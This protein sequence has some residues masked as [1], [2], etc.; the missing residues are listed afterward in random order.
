MDIEKSSEFVVNP[1]LKIEYVKIKVSDLKSSLDFYKSILGLTLLEERSN[2]NIAYL[3]PEAKEENMS[4]PILVLNQIERS[5]DSNKVGRV[6]KETGLYHFAILLPK[7]THLASFL[8]HVKNNLNSR[9]YEGMADHA[10][11]ESIYLHDPD[12][13]GIEVYRDRNPAEWTWTGKNTVY[14]TTEPLDV[15]DLLNKTPHESWNGMPAMTTI[16]HI[17]LR[18]SNLAE[19]K[20]FYHQS[21]GLNHTASYPGANFFAAN[22]YHHHVA[23]NNWIGSNI[24]PNSANDHSTTGLDHFAIRIQGGKK[25]LNELRDHLVKSNL[26]VDERPAVLGDRDINSF[27]VYDPD[28]IKMRILFG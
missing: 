17:H 28:G 13:I 12:H 16:G 21:L 4:E 1:S 5:D 15:D 25:D 7:R 24:T 10:V 27:Y 18:V 20:R 26:V 6:K 8:N 23:T 14:M 11:S 3:G 19:S 22:G 2:K 9:F